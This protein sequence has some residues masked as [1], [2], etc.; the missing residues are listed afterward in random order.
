M[1]H[2]N[3]CIAPRSQ[4]VKL[5]S[6][7]KRREDKTVAQE[8]PPLS[9]RLSDAMV[10][11]STTFVASKHVMWMVTL[12]FLRRS[13]RLRPTCYRRHRSW[14]DRRRTFRSEEMETWPSSVSNVL[15][16][17]TVGPHEDARGRLPGALLAPRTYLMKVYLHLSCSTQTCRRVLRL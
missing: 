9:P 1:T 13:G 15:L 11:A 12:I 2:A 7:Y 4:R 14:L 8:T 6:L 10:L 3:P 16:P 5:S 17:S